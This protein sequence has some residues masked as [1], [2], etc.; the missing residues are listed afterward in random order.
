MKIQL[1]IESFALATS[2]FDPYYNPQA[3]HMLRASE[4]VNWPS[5][6]LH[7]GSSGV[8]CNSGQWL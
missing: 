1:F 6:A 4:T 5:I 3:S 8:S 7:D 2:Q